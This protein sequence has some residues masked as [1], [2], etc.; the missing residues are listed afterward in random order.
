VYSDVEHGIWT[1]FYFIDCREDGKMAGGKSRLFRYFVY[2][3]ATTLDA[4]IPL[5]LRAYGA[6]E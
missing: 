5:E 3:N 4:C 1:G 6:T 2:G